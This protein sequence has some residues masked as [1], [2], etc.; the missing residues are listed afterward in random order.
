LS[1]K[2]F[3]SGGP[4]SDAIGHGSLDPQSPFLRILLANGLVERIFCYSFFMKV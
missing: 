2:L 3:P 4:I 1:D